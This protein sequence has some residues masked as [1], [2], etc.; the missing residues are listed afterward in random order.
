MVSFNKNLDRGIL[1]E[2]WIKY[3]FLVLKLSNLSPNAVQSTS[4]KR[5]Y[6]ED[7]VAQNS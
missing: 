3:E 4:C 7:S 2:G 5:C 6:R 1:E